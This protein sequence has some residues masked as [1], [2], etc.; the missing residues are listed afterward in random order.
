MVFKIKRLTAYRIGDGCKA[1]VMLTAFLW[2]AGWVSA[3]M[4]RFIPDAG[5]SWNHRVR[6]M[7]EA[8]STIDV[9]MF[10]W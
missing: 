6:L 3:D 10:I 2:L 8:K 7:K 9:A 4:V 1:W 5:D